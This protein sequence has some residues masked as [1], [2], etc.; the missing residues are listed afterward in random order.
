[1]A[2]HVEIIRFDTPYDSKETLN[3]LLSFG[4]VEKVGD[5]FL[6]THKSF[7][8]FFYVLQLYAIKGNMLLNFDKQLSITMT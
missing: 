4:V 6:F 5:D 8:E 3:E 7:E 2:G 1:M